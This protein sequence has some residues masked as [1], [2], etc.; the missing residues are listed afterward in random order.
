M[1]IILSRQRTEVPHLKPDPMSSS[2]ESRCYTY[3]YLKASFQLAN[4]LKNKAL[5]Y[6]FIVWVIVNSCNNDLCWQCQEPFNGG[7]HPQTLISNSPFLIIGSWTS[8]TC[9]YFI[10]FAF[11]L[12]NYENCYYYR[13]H[14]RDNH[15]ISTGG[16][17][18]WISPLLAPLANHATHLVWVFIRI[19]WIAEIDTM[20]CHFSGR[21][22]RNMKYM[23]TCEQLRF[24]SF[25]SV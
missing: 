8:F 3:Y 2:I 25:S 9:Y 7:N 10:T 20:E 21:W 22:R 19:Y 1:F 12:H 4:N 15:E 16:W 6:T 18:D 11:N 5:C 14:M 17:L 13:I 23:F 24:D